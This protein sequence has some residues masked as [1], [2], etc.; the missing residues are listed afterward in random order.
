MLWNTGTVYRRN[1]TFGLPGRWIVAAVLLV[2]VMLL[3]GVAV[4]QRYGSACEGS[5]LDAA[6]VC[7]PPAQP[8]VVPRPLP[9]HAPTPRID[10]GARAA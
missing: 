3:M 2:L 10:F 9:G 5:S 1:T 8:Q 7:T 6:V 4:L